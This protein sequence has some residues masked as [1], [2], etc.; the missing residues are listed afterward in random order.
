MSRAE[1]YLERSQ[2]YAASA[3]MTDN[4]TL[5]ATLLHLAQKY[6]ELA[7]VAQWNVTLQ[8]I[9]DGVP[10]EPSTGD[11]AEGGS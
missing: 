3:A 10:V 2:S 8:A 5:R 9:N 7:S 1:L 4:P 6:T 11:G